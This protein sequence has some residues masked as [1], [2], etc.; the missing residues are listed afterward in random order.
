MSPKKVHIWC[1]VGAG[2]SFCSFCS[3]SLHQHTTTPNGKAFKPCNLQLNI[4]SPND[5]FE[6]SKSLLKPTG[7]KWHHPHPHG[8][9]ISRIEIS[10]SEQLSSQFALLPQWPPVNV[11][12]VHLLTENSRA[13]MSNSQDLPSS[14]PSLPFVQALLPVFISQNTLTQAN[15]NTAKRIENLNPKISYLP[16]S[17]FPLFPWLPS[18]QVLSRSRTHPKF[19]KTPVFALIRALNV[20]CPNP[21]HSELQTRPFSSKKPRE[22]AKVHV[23]TL[24]GATAPSRALGIVYTFRPVSI[25]GPDAGSHSE[26]LCPGA[27]V[28]SLIFRQNVDNRSFPRATP[29]FTSFHHS[30]ARLRARLPKIHCQQFSTTLIVLWPREKHQ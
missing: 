26:S 15:P 16:R 28:V 5:Q 27:S 20:G 11:P 25:P 9:A 2:I 1:I 10:N 6:P 19:Q 17:S 18:V 23:S 8:T 14:L 21:A 12:L 30:N 3:R 13:A 22:S 7:T 4:S 29:H 24:P